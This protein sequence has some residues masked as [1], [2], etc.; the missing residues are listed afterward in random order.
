MAPAGIWPALGV[1][2]Q[3]AMDLLHPLLDAGLV[4]KIGVTD[5]HAFKM[6]AGSTRANRPLSGR[7]VLHCLSNPT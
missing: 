6:L 3:G 7:F 1:S 4:E 5:R 2:R